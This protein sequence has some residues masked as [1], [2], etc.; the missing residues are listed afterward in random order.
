M[1][2]LR[3]RT[4]ALPNSPL[5]LSA[6]WVFVGLFLLLGLAWSARAAPPPRLVLQ[7][8][9]DQLRGD[10]LLRY[11]E[12]FGPGGFRLLLD[13][14]RY[15]ANAHYETSNTLTASGHAVLVTGA[16]TA[17]HGIVAN[18]WWDRATG[19]PV[20]CTADARYPV[21]G[22]PAKPGAGMSP[23]RLTSSTVGDELVLAGAGR[24]RAF[25]VAGKDRSAILPAGHLGIALWFSDKTGAFTSSSFYFPALP[26]WVDAW[27]A[28]KPA[29]RYR[30]LD[31]RPLREPTTYRFFA[32]AANPLARPDP[33]LGRAFPHPLLAKSD[34]LFFKALLVTPFLDELTAALATELLDR[35]KLGQRDATDYLSISFSGNDYIGHAYGP[36]SMEAEDSLLRL[37]ATLAALFTHLERT[38]GLARTVI[39]LSADH[40]VDDIPEAHRTRGRSADR[41]F[42]EKIRAAANAALRSHF[43]VADD[44]VAAFMPPGLYLDAKKLSALKLDPVAVEAALAAHLRSAPGVAHALTRTDLLAGRV[45]RSALLDRVQ[46]GFH[47][48]RSG[49][50][51]I[52]QQP[53]WYMY[54]D[55]EGYAAMHGSPYAYDTFVP[56]IVLAPGVAAGLSHAA[57]S[58][59]QIAP[60]LAALLEISPPSGCARSIPLPGVLTP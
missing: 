37:D 16:D 19:Q 42:P 55:A 31:W 51:V 32:N 46:R 24:S 56:V 15:F 5:S 49:D 21:F 10:Q 20:Y 30:R 35:E 52:V 59:A 18:D 47:P 25:A 33:V 53:F 28:P 17:E 23:H 4:S 48:S 29:D 57:V 8:T 50:V 22:D 36:D 40:G 44:L 58:P 43:G 34:A 7:L 1:S 12:K 39:V 9:V 6:A 11:R 13:R 38:V 26:A 41:F 3:R 27:N 45:P 60:T 2:A 54:S 14:G